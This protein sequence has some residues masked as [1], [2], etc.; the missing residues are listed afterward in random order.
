MKMLMIKNLTKRFGGITA[1]NTVSFDVERKE[2]V[3]LIGPNGAGKTTLFNVIGGELAPEE[4]R[5]IFKGKDIVGLSPHE[6]CEKGVARTFQQATIFPSL[7]L[8][9]NVM[10]GGFI[11]TSKIE[12]VKQ[13][14]ID[15]I[16]RFGLLSKKNVTATNLTLLD[17][18]TTGLIRALMT[19][20]EL[21]L[22]DE[23]FV[24]LNPKEIEK[25]IYLVKKEIVDGRI[26]AIIVEHI[27]DVIL[28]ISDKIVVLHH[29]EK[30]ADDTPDA[31]VKDKKVI[32]AYLG[33]G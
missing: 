28:S 22:L 20:P 17:R 9:E 21:I 11:K 7:T 30:I 2:M 24:G 3:G 4:G 12:V 18:K 19:E 32:K 29:G 23:I 33:E 6:C 5:I 8:L 25:M 27:M 26:T 14:A 13:K 31:V 16:T 1:I 10:I 15:I